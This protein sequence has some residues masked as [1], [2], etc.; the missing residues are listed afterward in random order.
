MVIFTIWS[1]FSGAVCVD[2]CAPVPVAVYRLQLPEG[3]RDLDR[4]TRCD[5]PLPILRFL[6][7]QLW[8]DQEGERRSMHGT[9][10]LTSG[11]YVTFTRGRNKFV[12][13]NS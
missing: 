6:Q 13:E 1:T 11:H 3:L 10:L 7:V 8:K 2:I 4:P 12:A 9:I 5:V